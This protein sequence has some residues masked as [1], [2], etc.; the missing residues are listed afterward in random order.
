M[1][2]IAGMTWEICSYIIALAGAMI[3]EGSWYIP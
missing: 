3:Y 2:D 1:G